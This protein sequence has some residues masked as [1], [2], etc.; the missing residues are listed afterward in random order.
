MKLLK[1]T[2][3]LVSFLMLLTPVTATENNSIEFTHEEKIPKEVVKKFLE[4]YQNNDNQKLITLLAKDYTVTNTSEVNERTYCKYNEMS[5]N[6]KVRLKSLHSALPSFSLEI[7]Q[8][9]SEEDKV[10]AKY[11]ISGLQKGSFL[12][13]SPTKKP[14]HINIQSVFTVKYGKITHMSEMWNELSIMRQIGCVVL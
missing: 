6:L 2:L 3:L 7:K 8:L 14:V 12:G 4:C 13:A 9:L 11:T 5:K 1:K 10:F